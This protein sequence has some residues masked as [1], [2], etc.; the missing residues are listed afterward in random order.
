MLYS[1]AIFENH[2]YRKKEFNCFI[3]F[4]NRTNFVKRWFHLDIHPDRDFVSD[5][6]ASKATDRAQQQ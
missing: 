1:G 2:A 4:L 5:P 3:C 6:N